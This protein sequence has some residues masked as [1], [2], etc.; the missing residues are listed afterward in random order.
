MKTWLH[1]DCRHSNYQMLKRK[2]FLFR[3]LARKCFVVYIIIHKCTV[4]ILFDS[5][6]WKNFSLEIIGYSTIYLLHKHHTFEWKYVLFHS[7][8]W[9]HFAV[10]LIRQTRLMF[11]LKNMILWGLSIAA[12]IHLNSIF[13]LISGCYDFGIMVWCMLAYIY[14]V[15]VYIA[16]YTVHFLFS[17]SVFS[18]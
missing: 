16:F 12:I 3:S 2:V 10:Y 11:R 6:T 13:C 1:T 8:A 18:L 17:W 7:F 14:Q 5:H 15:F 4:N 9:K